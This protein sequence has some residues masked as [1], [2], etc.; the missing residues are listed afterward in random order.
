MESNYDT[1]LGVM[2]VCLL[3]GKIMLQS[4][5]ETY[6]VED[7][8]IRM[9]SA[10]QL[11]A[12]S[13]VTPTGIIFTINDEKTN[14]I[15]VSERSIDLQKITRVNSISR[16]FCN[17]SLSLQDTYEELVAVDVSSH[18]YS[19]LLQTI[20]AALVSGCFL[21]M[22]QG[23]WS[24][25]F[26]ALIC[27]GLGF[28][29]AF[30][31]HRLTQ[32]KFFAEFLASLAIGLCAIMFVKLGVGRFEDKIIVA[33]VMPLVPGLLITNAVRDLMAGHLVSG[34]SKGIEAMLT[35]MAIGGGIAVALS[36][37]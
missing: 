24:N 28:A 27:G 14:L 29:L 36:L 23:T 2:D 7:T 10:C 22:F 4:G 17:G 9:A 15:R 34:M 6:R 3:A 18:A 35:A 1:N 20:T 25:F 21:I 12:H 5:A 37:L 13:F 31:F 32:V 19:F 16:S 11:S 26:N 33:A 8:M 30:Y